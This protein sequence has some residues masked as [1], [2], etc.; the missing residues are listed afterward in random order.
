MMV[1]VYSDGSAQTIKTPG[2]W[3]YV[4]VVNGSKE[5][6]GSGC[7]PNATNNDMELQAAIE[8]LKAAKDMIYRNPMLFNIDSTVTLVGDSQI[9]LGWITGKYEFKQSDKLDKYKELMQ[10]ANQLRIQTRWVKGHDGNLFNE[11]CDRL[12]NE[13]RKSMLPPEEPKVKKEKKAKLPKNEF[14]WNVKPKLETPKELWDPN[15]NK[16]VKEVQ[17][18]RT[19]K[20]KLTAMTGGVYMDTSVLV[21]V[22]EELVELE[23]RK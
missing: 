22:L 5:L 2:G 1:E 19:D 18:L 23:E 12:A 9:V 21:R 6:S 3:G 14:R 8:G 13:A 16:F 7:T 10:L 4:V 17:D 20:E 11:E 15:I